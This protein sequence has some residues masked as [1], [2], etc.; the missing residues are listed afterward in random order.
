MGT[1]R[2]SILDLSAAGDQPMESGRYVLAFN[3]EVY[4]HLEIRD[5]LRAAGVAPFRSSS[6]TETILRAVE[7]WGIPATLERLNGM[8]A[9]AIWDKVRAEL[10]LA[11]D[12][13]GVKPL[14]YASGPQGTYFASELK[15]LR[16]FTPGRMSG[17]GVALFLLLGFVPAPFSLLQQV[18]KVRPGEALVF[19]RDGV[20][21][22]RT[23]PR[24]WTRATGPAPRPGE[25]L[26]LVRREVEAAV[27]RQL[28]ADVPVGLFLSGGINSS[29]IAA[30]AAAHKPDLRTFSIRPAEAFADPGAQ[31]D[32]EIAA[33][34]ARS[35]G[36][37]H[38]ELLVHPDEVW[39]ELDSLATSM[40]EPVSELYFAAE[41]LLSWAA[42]TAGVPVVLTGHGA[43]EVFLGYPTYQAV[44]KG[45]RY[46]A[47]PLLGPTLRAL[48]RLPLLTPGARRNSA[49][50]RASGAGRRPTG[51]P[52]SPPSTSHCRR[53]RPWPT[54]RRPRSATCSSRSWGRRR[55]RAPTSPGAGP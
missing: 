1:R 12:P 31:E 8:F 54:C 21:R 41:V 17:E 25:Q 18:R 9:L 42:R 46:N 51:T 32:A 6:D 29:I 11:R 33:R 40:D 4:N 35:L 52:S 45:D 26:R 20:T 36:L 10:T 37:S 34:F 30:V 43:D 48:A 16:R 38:H 2:L 7:R 53:S 13:L 14:L 47:V 23:V 44:S 49:A 19:G 5:E 39:D 55:R 15:A 28:L 24:A 27:R 50:R 22:R 3:G